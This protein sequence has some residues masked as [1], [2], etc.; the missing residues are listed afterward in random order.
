MTYNPNDAA[1][2][3]GNFAGLPIHTS[4]TEIVYVPV[5]WDITASNA[6]GTANGP[7][8]ILDSSLQI[9]LYDELLPSAWEVHREF[10]PINEKTVQLNHELSQKL[11][12]I[13]GD[14]H[15]M[16]ESLF[17][18]IN[19]ACAKVHTN[20]FELCSAV[21]DK[22]QLPFVI[23]GDHSSAFGNIRAVSEHYD[24]IDIVQ[25]DAHLDLRKAYEGFEYSHASIFFNAMTKLNIGQLFCVG[26]RDFCP[27]EMEFGR[28]LGDRYHLMTAQQLF[29]QLLEGRDYS[30]IVKSFIQKLN[31]KVYLSLDV[32]AL[33]LQ[34]S[35]NTGTPVPG[36]L[37]YYHIIYLVR[38]IVRSGRTIVGLDLCE[39]A[40]DSYVDGF[41]SAKLVYALSNMAILS[42]KE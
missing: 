32:D 19:E 13:Q 35:L 1:E 16:T 2:A 23:G 42:R 20:T 3:N 8:N 9:D 29:F 7:K 25:I 31:G 6:K 22:G 26:A 15:E 18:R 14:N 4:K 10:R 24:A 30:S 40:G 5:P 37:H 11:E 34:Y 39:T 12:S 27:E 41:T 28:N 17:T 21:L 38:E 33:D 36:G